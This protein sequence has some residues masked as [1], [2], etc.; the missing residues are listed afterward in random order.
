MLL[1]ADFLLDSME[2]TELQYVTNIHVFTLHPYE[3]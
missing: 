3:L 1:S 2:E